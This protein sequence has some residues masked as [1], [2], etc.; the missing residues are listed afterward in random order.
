MAA[1]GTAASFCSTGQSQPPL[2]GEP[3]WGQGKGGGRRGSSVG[4]VRSCW[5][6]RHCFVCACRRGATGST[7]ARTNISAVCGLQPTCPQAGICSRYPCA[8]PLAWLTLSCLQGPPP[9]TPSQ[10]GMVSVGRSGWRWATCSSQKTQPSGRG[11]GG[12]ALADSGHP[13]SFL[14][15]PLESSSWRRPSSCHFP[16]P[17]GTAPGHIF[18]ISWALTG[19]FERKNSLNVTKGERAEGPCMRVRVDG[20][21]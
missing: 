8:S 19:L 16:Q 5:G 10:D 21:G 7:S 11:V 12:R 18:G 9:H 6:A 14:P 20:Q 1:R 17:S 15:F 4:Q 2:L 13:L 3:P